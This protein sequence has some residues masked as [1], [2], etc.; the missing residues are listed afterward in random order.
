MNRL[1][2]VLVVSLPFLAGAKTGNELLVYCKVEESGVS[3]GFCLGYI[4]GAVDVHAS[5]EFWRSEIATGTKDPSYVPWVCN[6]REVTLGQTKALFMKYAAENPDSLH[7]QGDWLI[8][9][10]M[11]KAFPCHKK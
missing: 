9:A 11:R 2:I 1:A 7:L 5:W 8:L 6:P 4:Q 10:A 3:T